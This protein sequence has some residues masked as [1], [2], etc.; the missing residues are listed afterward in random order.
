M[1]VP[2]IVKMA[3]FCKVDYQHWAHEMIILQRRLSSLGTKVIFT[4]LSSN[5]SV[6]N[7]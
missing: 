6:E 5:A 4:Y 2:K 7:A 1:V 3:A